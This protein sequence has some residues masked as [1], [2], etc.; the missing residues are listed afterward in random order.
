MVIVLQQRDGRAR[1]RAGVR[2]RGGPRAGA[3]PSRREHV[4]GL[5]THQLAP[6]QVSA[7]GRTVYEVV[8]LDLAP[9]EFARRA[10][11]DPGGASRRCPGCASMLAGGPAFYGDIQE[12]SERDLQRSEFISL[13]LAALALLL[14]FGSVV[15]AGVPIVDWRLGRGHRARR[16]CSSSPSRRR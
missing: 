7:D 11:A 8:T 9:D 2:A 3:R 15:A 14:V 10:G 6:R 13:P 4:T 5:L 16:R 1:G 12:L